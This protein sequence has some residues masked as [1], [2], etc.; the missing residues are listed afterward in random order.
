MPYDDIALEAEDKMEKA[1][2]VLVNELRGVRTGRASPG[3]VDTIKVDYY[4]EPTMLKA[5]AS[6]TVPE[7][8]MIV[9]KPFDPGAVDGIIKGIQKSDVGLTPQ[10]DGKIIRLA[11][12]P[13]SEERRK[14]MSKS[15]KELGEKAKISMRNIRREGNSTADKEEKDKEMSEDEAKRTKTEM[16][17][18]TKEYEG[19]VQETL[20]RKTKEVMEI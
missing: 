4:G 2:A 1:V 3:L 5:L 16:D 13:L 6:I 15:V 17:R 19:K 20:E 7:P 8:R 11:V 12:P 10:T 9:L 14:Q 18:L